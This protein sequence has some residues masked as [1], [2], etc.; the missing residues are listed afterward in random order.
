MEIFE[1]LKPN[2]TIITPNRRLTANLTANFNAY[3]LAKDQ[4]CWPTLDILPYQSWIQRLWDEM[5]ITLMDRQP[6]ILSN[7]QEHIIWENILQK[8]PKNDS[9]LQLSATAELVKSA[10][11][12]LKQWQID[13]AHPLLGMSEDSQAFQEWA[14]A[15]Q[16]YCEANHCIDHNTAVAK[17]IDYIKNK[18]TT[19]PDEIIVAGFTELSPIQH[20]LLKTYESMDVHITFLENLYSYKDQ[21]HSYISL[22]DYETE[23][24][25]MAK[26][27]KHLINTHASLNI[28]CIIPNLENNR[29]RIM[30]IFSEVFANQDFNI[31]AGK[32]L[33]NYPV[34]YAVMQIL[35]LH[36]ENIS[37]TTLSYLLRTP[38]LGEAER[39]FTNRA[40]FDS[41]LRN[42]NIS[43]LSIKELTALNI[44]KY[45]PYFAKR[46]NALLNQ[47]QIDSLLPSE[48]VNHI[49][50]RLSILGWPGERSI[51]SQE[52]QVVQ[53]F[54]ELLNEYKSFDA[55]TAEIS[56]NEAIQHLQLLITKIVFQPQSAAAPVQILGLLEAATL[57]FDYTWVAGLDDTAWPPAARPNPFIPH[58]LQKTLN[59]PH[60]TADK[61]LQYSAK[62]TS[63]LKQ[64]TKMII[65]S[66]ALTLDDCD[67]RPS[68]LIA[69]CPKL[70]LN[71]IPQNDFIS[72]AAIIHQSKLTESLLDEQAP[73]VND[74]EK[75]AGGV[76]L[77]KQQAACGFK[78]FAE[79]RLHAKRLK[80]ASIG[81]RPE[82]RG[83]ITHK[84]LELL[85][86]QLKDYETLIH[87]NDLNLKEII[88]QCVSDAIQFKVKNISA[89]PKYFALESERLQNLLW[90]WLELEKK[91]SPFKV[92]SNEEERTLTV[93]DISLNL[94][95]DR[96]DQLENGD[97]CVIDYKTG[98][99]NFIKY[100]FGE[101]P[102]EPQLPLYCLSNPEHVKAI[103]FGE[104]HPDKLALSGV[105]Q[106][107]LGIDKIKSLHEINYTE[108]RHWEDQIQAWKTVF[109]KLAEEFIQGNA[110][111]S[112]KHRI[113]TCQ[114]CDLK[115][116]CRIHEHQ[117]E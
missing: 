1:K 71:D 5:T 47:A 93:G 115:P 89:K 19:L 90:N 109:A 112:P 55:I 98:K 103:A 36:H 16:D 75:L 33:A 99:S 24:I 11:A 113:E 88:A 84:A 66:H 17:I 34:I 25:T 6:T 104:V 65:F 77:F 82:D 79:I 108:T 10:W 13:L 12:T 52:Y 114:Y 50:E 49:M 9:L 57:P 38:F 96:I 78:A 28:G 94:R 92:I 30:Q 53:R 74:D 86:K 8:S 44:E 15:F 101:R 48:W 51:D 40:L 81:L 42:E 59:M 83:T 29:D 60:A 106:A 41:H 76:N 54:L 22:P 63:Q 23:I 87:L 97:H 31:S 95:V 64:N 111:V 35:K 85:W 32:S 45:C 72:P 107:D 70:S 39:E 100:W 58:K 26:W 7:H 110:S 43:T 21:T 18:L 3:Q 69:D 14:Y 91:R 4:R 67:L 80:S 62:L 68:A 27:A 2:T 61:E 46:I 117:A 102:E 37:M 20:T 105:S 56:F 116:L 73:K